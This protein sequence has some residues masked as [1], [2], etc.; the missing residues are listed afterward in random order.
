MVHV[1]ATL[2]RA[3]VSWESLGVRHASAAM[4]QDDGDPSSKTGAKAQ[5]AEAR[6]E[7]D[8]KQSGRYKKVCLTDPDATMATSARNRRPEPAYE[9][10]IAVDDVRGVTLDVEVKTGD[11]NE[12]GEIEGRADAVAAASRLTRRASTNPRRRRPSFCLREGGGVD[13][14]KSRRVR[15]YLSPFF[16]RLRTGV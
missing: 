6:A 7:R 10:H 9:Q 13:W 12:G 1:D 11:V 3:D 4:A 2:I 15:R 16:P 8:G 5:S 14:R